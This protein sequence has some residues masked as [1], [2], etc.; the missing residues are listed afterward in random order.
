MVAAINYIESHKDWTDFIETV[1]KNTGDYYE[2]LWL[3]NAKANKSLIKKWGWAADS[4]QD[5][6]QGKTSVLLGASPAIKNQTKK[7]RELREDPE[8]VFMGI[9]SG[10]E[11]LLS[12]GIKP[13]YA[14]IAD[15][16]PA[17]ERFWKNLDMK[18]TKDITL[19]ANIC[20][21]PNLLKMWQGDIK[22]LAIHAA[23]KKVDHKFRKWFRG[24]NGS[25]NP[26]FALSSQYNTGAAFAFTV[27]GTSIMIFVGNE[28]GFKDREVSYYVNRE[29]VKDTW[30]RKPHPDINGNVVYTNYMLMSLKLA[31][32]DFLGKLS[33]AGW[34]FNCTEAGIFGVSARHGNLPWIQQFNLTTG[35]AQARSIMR[36]GEPYYDNRRIIK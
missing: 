29:D 30:L 32:E 13:H 4:L 8:F 34:F 17:V 14:M 3:D 20:V 7:L 31:L 5:A 16:D 25:G 27:L 26:F 22:F 21:H 36:T 11:F 9:A 1:S 12:E 10:L 15:A 18:E 19:I 2:D 23:I 35:I 28:L 33:G 24:M 6:E